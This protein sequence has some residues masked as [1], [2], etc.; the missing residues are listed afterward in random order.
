[1]TDGKINLD[2]PGSVRWQHN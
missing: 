2:Y 1:M